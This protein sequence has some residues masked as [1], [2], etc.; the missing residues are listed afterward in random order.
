MNFLPVKGDGRTVMTSDFVTV[1]DGILR[2]NDTT[3]ESVK[4]DPDI[5][6]Q[7]RILGEERVRRAGIILDVGSD[8]Y[9]NTEKCIP[10][11]VKVCTTK[12]AALAK[13]S[14]PTPKRCGVVVVILHT[15]NNTTLGSI[16]LT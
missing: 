5:A 1:V 11:F 7:I 15:N 4:E 12:E 10:D 8:G 6:E 16:K 3:W 14:C 9:Y 2:Y 13:I